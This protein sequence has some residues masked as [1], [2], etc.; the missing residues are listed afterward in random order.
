MVAK[1]SSHLAEIL[2]SD[3]CPA[4]KLRETLASTMVSKWCD[5]W[6]SQP[7]K[8]AKGV[9]AT[10]NA[11]AAS[12]ETLNQRTQI[13]MGPSQ[14]YGGGG[15]NQ[16]D[17]ILGVLCTTHL[18]TYL[19]GGWDI[20]CPLKWVKPPSDGRRSFFRVWM[21]LESPA[22]AA[23]H[24]KGCNSYLPKCIMPPITIYLPK[25]RSPCLNHHEKKG[26]CFC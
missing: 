22:A 12:T 6:I 23:A 7:S 4:V 14:E 17:P 25:C 19:S 18:R 9:L 13:A 8:V 2:V 10:C 24:G 3:D 1:S 11:A 15:Q 26:D 5:F 20:T 21:H 16:W